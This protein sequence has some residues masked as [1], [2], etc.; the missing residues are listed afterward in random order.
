MYMSKLHWSLTD[1]L[2]HFD[3]GKSGAQLEMWNGQE[4]LKLRGFHTDLV[5]LLEEIHLESFRLQA[6]VAAPGPNGFIGL[7][8]GTRDAKNYELVYISPTED[9][10]VKN[11]QYDPIMN[12]SSTWQ[13]YN[14][15]AYQA[16]APFPVGQWTKFALEVQPHSVAVYVGD[17]AATPQLVVSSLQ[18]GRSNSRVGFWGNMP[19]YIRNFSVDEI[20]PHPAAETTTDFRKLAADSFVTH[21]QVSEPF[22][23]NE[24]EEYRGGWKEAAVEENGCLNVNRLYSAGNKGSAVLAKC[25][26][27]LEEA[28]DSVISFG[29]SDRLRMWVNDREVYQGLT[30][31]DPPHSDGR[32]RPDH[33]QIPIRWSAGENTILAEITN[34]EGMFGWGL[35]VK[36]GLTNLRLI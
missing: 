32:I 26:F 35:A 8:F 16:F 33:E 9:P 36:T 29:F 31:W 24:Q 1:D 11:I 4:V 7:A 13:I 28:T 27:A 5:L 6:E 21:W 15:P 20:A 18:H 25:T 19:G 10:A 22:M 12:G 3:L 17:E 34:L 23:P 14:G 30:K 2:H